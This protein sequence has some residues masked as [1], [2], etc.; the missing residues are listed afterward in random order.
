VSRKEKQGAWRGR[1]QRPSL[2]ISFDRFPSEGRQCGNTG[3]RNCKRKTNRIM[4]PRHTIL[5]SVSSE[6][7]GAR[8]DNK[9]DERVGTKERGGGTKNGPATSEIV[10]LESLRDDKSCDERRIMKGGKRFC[11]P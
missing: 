9:D 11:F 4:I 1:K 2:G 3:K 8:G 7:K 10:I 6:Q 5:P